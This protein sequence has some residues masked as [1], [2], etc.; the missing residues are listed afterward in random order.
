MTAFVAVTDAVSYLPS[1]KCTAPAG[2]RSAQ[3]THV[4]LDRYTRRRT[5]RVIDGGGVA[6]ATD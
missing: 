4:A 1:L 5:R 3:P 6:T 2:P